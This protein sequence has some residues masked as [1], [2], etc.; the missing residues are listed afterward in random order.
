MQSK[1]LNADQTGAI[2]EAARLL[3]S[4]HL[5]AFPTDTL[6]GVGA[7]IL[8]AQAIQQL[9]VAKGRSLKKGIP[10][11]LSD[12][13][14]L[15]D[16]VRQTPDFALSL[17]QKFWPGPLTL[18]LP[19][20]DHIPGIISPDDN[21]AVRVPDNDV[22]RKFIR[23]AGGMVVTSSANRSGE[24]PALNAQEALAALGDSIAAVL[25]GGRVVLGVASTIV[26]CTISPPRI[27]REGPL[28]TEDLSLVKVKET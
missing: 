2:E 3:K 12:I 14:K 16:I 13:G 26:D 18:I 4:G 20:Q 5:I 24:P 27:L 23:A 17:A 11:L 15:E 25:D 28:S 19:K 8:N 7:D 10:V 22:A 1:L 9:Y 6:Y 21:V